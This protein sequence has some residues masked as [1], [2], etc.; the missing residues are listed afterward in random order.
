MTTI[1]CHGKIVLESNDQI[2]EIFKST[3]FY[4]GIVFDLSDVDYVDS[5]GLGTRS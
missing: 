1:K 2:M 5:A 3:P 4:D